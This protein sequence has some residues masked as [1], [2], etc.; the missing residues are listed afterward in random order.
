MSPYPPPA[1]PPSTSFTTTRLNASTFL[2]TED[3]VYSERPFIY[4]KLHPHHPLLI[5]SDSGCAAP[6]DPSLSLTCLRTY[7]ETYPVPCNRG[8]PL[9]PLSGEGATAGRAEREYLV[10]CTHCHYDHI[11]ALEQFAPT[12]TATARATVLASSRGRKFVEED[13]PTHSLCRFQDP[14]IPTPR[15]RVGYWADDNE[16]LAYP[17]PSR[18]S[19]APAAATPPSA[20]A[21]ATAAR[22]W[23]SRSCTRP[24][25]RRT[26]SRGTTR[27]SAG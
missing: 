24:A 27:Q 13:L 21:A 10:I 20:A 25:T 7:L 12:P 18:P 1:P 19:C 23:T 5:L 3:D 15:Y 17:F 22:S 2:I 16:E 26:S 6:R 8:R 4:A 11:G 9:N 14:P